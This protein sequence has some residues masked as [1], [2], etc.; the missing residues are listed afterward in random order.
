MSAY[1]EFNMFPCPAELL[2]DKQP[3]PLRLQERAIVAKMACEK[4]FTVKSQE[5][6]NALWHRDPPDGAAATYRSHVSHIR[7]AA[8]V[9]AGDAAG[10]LLVT[11][12]VQGGAACRLGIDP[13][14]IDVWRWENDLQVARERMQWEPSRVAENELTGVLA[15]W[16]RD[17]FQDV[18]AW[19]FG[20][21]ALRQLRELRR[22]ARL[23]LADFRIGAGRFREVTVDLALLA[24]EFPGEQAIWERLITSYWRAGQDQAA[25]Q[26][27]R[28]ATTTFNELGLDVSG[29]NRLHREI[30]SGTVPR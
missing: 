3:I 29:L 10:S 28:D 6:V 4:D 16:Q 18:I 15:R 27:C 5:M 30:L 7:R 21:A 9:V 24:G 14:S 22:D 20:R 2:W 13:G 12:R 1:F 8:L 17:P 25:A 26:A 23:Q 19:A 11:L